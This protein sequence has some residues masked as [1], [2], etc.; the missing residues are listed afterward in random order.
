MARTGRC[1]V[2]DA[3]QLAPTLREVSHYSVDHDGR[4]VVSADPTVD[5]ETI[6]NNAFVGRDVLRSFAQR[7]GLPLIDPSGKMI[8][9]V[10]LGNDPFMKYDSH[11]NALGHK[12]VAEEVA[13]VLQYAD[14]P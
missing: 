11:W 8:Q 7:N 10:K 5:V 6:Q 1:A 4:L 9:S 2:L 14:C 13:G 12:I 3:R